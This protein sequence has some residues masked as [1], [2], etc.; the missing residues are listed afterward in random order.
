MSTVVVNGDTDH[1]IQKLNLLQE[2]EEQRTSVLILVPGPL[3]RR[4]HLSLTDP[5]L[6]L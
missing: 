3:K 1:Q 2:A 5:A 4:P 6:S